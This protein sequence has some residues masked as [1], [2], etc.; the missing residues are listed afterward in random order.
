MRPIALILFLVGLISSC[1]RKEAVIDP[2]DEP[3][4]VVLNDTAATDWRSI[5]PIAL[6]G[7][8]P[9]VWTCGTFDNIVAERNFVDSVFSKVNS[10]GG[11][12]ACY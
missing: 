3:M 8:K 11:G 1:S 12:W 2:L 7:V 4:I 5:G 10:G 9:F 6:R